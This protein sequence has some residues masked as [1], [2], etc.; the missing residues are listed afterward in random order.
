MAAITLITDY[1][2]AD[3]YAG[4]LKGVIAGIAPEAR[5]YD[6]T[7]EIE[8]YNVIHGAFVLRQIWSRFPVDTVHL[9]VVDPGV[10]TNRRVLLGR[11]DGRYVIAPDNGLITLVHRDFPVES[12]HVVENRRYFGPNLSSTFHGRDIMAPV[13]GHLCNEVP[14][15]EFG[16]VTDR[17]ELLDVPHEAQRTS[18]GLEG[19]VIHVDRFGTLVTNVR[20][21]QLARGSAPGEADVSVNGESIGPIRATFADVPTGSPVALIGSSDNLEI[22]VNQGSAAAYFGHPGPVS[23]EVRIK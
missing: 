4:V 6:I 16:P 12:M 3:A 5:I 8:P 22:A 1:G 2:T 19:R 17:V 18:T 20:E 13:A 9:A 21:A 11:Y 14:V 10:G 23:V 15:H 7:H